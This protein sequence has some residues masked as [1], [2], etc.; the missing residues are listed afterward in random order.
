MSESPFVPSGDGTHEPGLLPRLLCWLA[1]SERSRLEASDAESL[2][3]QLIG[4]SVLVTWIFA[5]LAWGY[6]FYLMFAGVWKALPLALFF[7]FAIMNIDRN[8]IAAVRRRK[9]LPGAFPLLLRLLLAGLIGLFL[10]QPLLLALFR[11]DI[12]SELLV[13]HQQELATFQHR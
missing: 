12:Q 13:R 3:I 4:L 1:V 7:G 8:L 5:S 11:E 6:Y 2:R 9:G 10:S